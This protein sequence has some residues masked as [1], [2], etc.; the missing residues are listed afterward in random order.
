M[1]SNDDLLNLS[2]EDLAKE[3]AEHQKR[4]AL[5]FEIVTG[6]ISKKTDGEGFI[7]DE[8]VNV[9]VYWLDVAR[10]YPKIIAPD[11][12]MAD[13]A[14]KTIFFSTLVS[15]AKQDAQIGEMLK[16]PRDIVSKDCAAYVSYIRKQVLD[17]KSDPVFKL[18]LDEEP[19]PRKSPTKKSPPTD[20]PTDPPTTP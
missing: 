10:D 9:A 17:R 15:L 20:P 8:N 6:R 13:F 1:V 3:I 2:N 19:S 14:S 16:K 4:T 7:K 11:K 5:L 12:D 18:I